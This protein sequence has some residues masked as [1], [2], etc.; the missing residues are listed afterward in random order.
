MDQYVIKDGV[1]YLGPDLSELER[2][3]FRSFENLLVQKGF[4]Y[5]SIPTSLPWEV[6]SRQGIVLP[7]YVLGVDD[8]HCLSG[9]AEQ[10]ILSYF[11]GREVE[12]C[13]LF[14]ENQCW[15]REQEL[16][17]LKTL[18]EFRK[19]EQFSFVEPSNWREEFELLL[20][21]AYQFLKEFDFLDVRVI[22][23]TDADPGYHHMKCD[24]E[25]K[26]ERYGWMETHSCSYFA[27]EQVKRFDI[28][29]DVHTISNTGL[30][31]PRI[32]IPFIEAGIDPC[33]VEIVSTLEELEP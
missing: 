19:I 1:A 24:I 9:S 20:E 8:V 25:V 15:R 27:D 29:G 12:P 3:L 31:S 21:N 18:Q 5:L 4:E 16:D 14:A 23:C 32:L 26:T 17:G 7:E 6:I 2:R 11:Q 22:E 33:E 13:R 30:A 10:G 28:E